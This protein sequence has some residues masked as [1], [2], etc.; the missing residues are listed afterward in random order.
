[1]GS[2]HVWEAEAAFDPEQPFYSNAPPCAPIMAHNSG[3]YDPFTECTPVFYLTK[4]LTPEKDIAVKAA[5]YKE[6]P[7]YGNGFGESEYSD[8][9]DEYEGDWGDI[10]NRKRKDSRFVPWEDDD[11]AS[12]DD[13]FNILVDVYN[14]L[15]M[16]RQCLNSFYID[17]DSPTDGCLLLVQ[18]D[19]YLSEKN[20]TTA[21]HDCTHSERIPIYSDSRRKSPYCN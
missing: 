18:A 17:R 20:Y 10:G 21:R 2:Y 8:F 1:M 13:I 19:F 4:E 11:D 14:Y 3:R 16:G 12:L 9:D 7:G 6:D 5:I 15:E